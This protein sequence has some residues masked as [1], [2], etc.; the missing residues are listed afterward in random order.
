MATLRDE[1]GALQSLL[2]GISAAGASIVTINQSTP[3]NGAA[4]VAVTI[5]TDTM[6]MTPE[7]LTEKLSRQRMVSACTAGTICKK[8][9]GTREKQW[10]KIAILGFGTVGSG[11]YEVLCRNA[12][13]CPAV[14][15][16]PVEVKHPWT[17]RIFQ[18]SGCK[19]V[20][21]ELR[22]HSGGPGGPGGGGDHRRHPLCLPVCKGLPESGRSVC[23]S[24]RRWWPPTARAAGPGQRRTTV[25]S[26]SR[27]P[28]AAAAHHH[29]HAPVPGGQTSSPR[30]RAS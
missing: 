7:E 30:W 18:P 3:E 6:Q 11:V 14:P 23:T 12:A 8:V 1:T 13:G 29:P 28:W 22:H 15:G 19:P 24:T 26:C 25:P 16:E 17:R 27:L 20:Y 10:L 4:L 9:L 2:A 21:Q 5:R